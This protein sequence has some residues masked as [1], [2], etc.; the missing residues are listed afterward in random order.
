MLD[1]PSWQRSAAVRRLAPDDRERLRADA[2][3]LLFLLA[4]LPAD[5]AGGADEFPRALELNAR[6]AS[7]YP[8]D[9]A[10]AALLRQ[11]AALVRQL[12]GEAE[13]ERL[14]AQAEA[15]PPRTPRDRCLLACA[16][17]AQNRFRA[18]LPLWQQACRDDPQNVWA[19]HGLGDCYAHLAQPAQAAA[20]YSACIALSPAFHGWYFRRGLA[21]LEQ[22][23]YDAAGADFDQAIRLRPEHAEAYVNRAVA[24]L[25]AGQCAAAIDDLTRALGLGAPAARVLLMRA[26]AREKAGDRDG[27]ERDRAEARRSEPADEAAWV[28]RGVA[29]LAEAPAD[30]L[31]DFERA[32]D[33]NPR[34]L[35]AL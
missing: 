13:A 8:D 14:L 22:E 33:R 5:P 32:L 26:R 31:A 1:D 30:A 28:A 11:R 4:A 19:W 16:Y 9:E 23:Q 15:T 17:A 20:C 18:A 25:N 7:C 29:R 34:Y 21:D 24:R 10:P 27:A 35:P 2:G 6:A 12:G 3:E